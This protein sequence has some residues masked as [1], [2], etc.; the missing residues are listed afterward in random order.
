MSPTKYML[1]T[2][3]LC[4]WFNLPL[5]CLRFRISLLPAIMD[6]VVSRQ[7]WARLISVLLRH[8]SRTSDQ[9]EFIF[10]ISWTRQ[11]KRTLTYFASLTSRLKCIKQQSYHQYRKHGQGASHWEFTDW[12]TVW[13]MEYWRIWGW[14]WTGWNSFQR[15]SGFTHHNKKP[16]LRR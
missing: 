7:Q 9:P 5:K 2:L 8:G 15:S 3:I 10:V 1:Q 16:I 6:V 4:Q 13:T 11:K 12:F 14:H